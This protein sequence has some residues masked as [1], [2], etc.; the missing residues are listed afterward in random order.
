MKRLVAILLL[1][2]LAVLGA[3][4]LWSRGDEVHRPQAEDRPEPARPPRP[5]HTPEGIATVRP[6]VRGRV[7]DPTGAPVEKAQVKLIHSDSEDESVV[8]GH[9]ACNLGLHDVEAV[10]V[11]GE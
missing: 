1:L 7:V 4:L 2:A 11:D 3:V 10:D 5:Q 6:M 8:A 9:C